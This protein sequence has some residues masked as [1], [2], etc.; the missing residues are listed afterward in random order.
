MRAVCGVFSSRRAVIC[1]CEA[2]S[3]SADNSDSVKRYGSSAY[4]FSRKATCSGKRMSRV[5]PGL[6]LGWRRHAARTETET[7]CH[8]LQR[9]AMLFDGEAAMQAQRLGGDFGGDVGVA[10]PIAAD[11]RRERQPARGA[12]Q[13][14]IMLR[15]RG[16]EIGV[17]ARQ[18]I[19]ENLAD[20]IQ[21]GADFV[22]DAG[23]GGARL[24]G[25]PQGC[26]F[27]AQRIQ[28]FVAL[29]RATDRWSPTDASPGRRAAASIGSC[30]ASLRW[31]A[32]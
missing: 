16:V 21:P 11:P 10:I 8:L 31:D 15:Q 12:A 4:R 18:H 29:V 2:C 26:D 30:G 14:R 19:P 5:E 20:E 32:R 22:G 3:R 7:A 23:L 13:L 25:E 1:S 28:H 27:G 17:E 9:L 24:I 6:Q